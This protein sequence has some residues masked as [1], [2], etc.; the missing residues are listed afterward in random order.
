MTQDSYSLSF[1]SGGQVL[2]HLNKISNDGHYS[3]SFFNNHITVYS[4]N[5]RLAIRSFH[6]LET[7]KFENIIDT[8]ISP[9]NSNL[10]YLLSGSP[11]ENYYIS[12]L[13]W[14][15]NSKNPIL[16]TLK[17]KLDPPST[18]VKILNF[19]SNKETILN[20]LI[21]GKKSYSIVSYDLENLKTLKIFKTIDNV[22][23][24]A[25]SPNNKNIVFSTKKQIPNFKV[26]TFDDD[27]N[28]ELAYFTVNYQ[29][30]K[31][32]ATNL[33]I[34]ND[35]ANP[36]LAFSTSSGTIILLFDL[37]AENPPQRIL[38]WHMGSPK[39]LIFNSDSNYLLSGGSEKVLVFWNILNEKQQFLP[40][41]NGTIENISLNPNVPSLMALSLNVIDNDF[42]YLILGTTDLLSKLDIS[43]PHLFSGM[44]KDNAI[45]KNL[46]KDLHYFEKTGKFSKFKHP[47]K[48]DFKINPKS[49]NLYLQSGRHLQIYDSLHN[50]QIDNLAVAPAVQQY[51]KVGSENKIQDPMVIGSEFV[52]CSK[53]NEMDW[54]V[55]CDAEVR[56]EAEEL[57]DDSIEHWETLRFWKNNKDDPSS[58]DSWTLQT[59]MLRPHGKY[60]ITNIVAAPKSYFGGEAVLTADSRGNV[61]LWRPN[62]QG[63]WSLRKFYSSGSE[64]SLDNTNLE[65]KK[66]KPLVSLANKEGTVCSWSPDSSMIA[67]GKEG[68]VVLLDVNTF[69]PIH[70]ISPAISSARFHTKH[71][72]IEEHSNNQTNGTNNNKSSIVNNKT[73][74]IDINLQDRHIISINFTSNGKLLIIETR[75]HVTV[76]DILKNKTI[77]G[78]MLSY[79]DTGFGGSIVKVTSRN[80]TSINFGDSTDLDNDTT[81]ELL[82]IGNFFSTNKEVSSKLTLWN[83]SDKKSTIKC[84]WSKI[85]NS[86]I[87]GAE[88]SESWQQWILAD[89]NSNIG[90]LSFG[91]SSNK[92]LLLK[93]SESTETSNWIVSSLL[94]NARIVNRAIVSTNEASDKIN[95]DDNTEEFNDRKG[96][97]GSVF[98]GILDHIDGVSVSTLF[99]RVLKVV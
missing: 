3:I 85:Y 66:N 63:I 75:S 90:E 79:K 21:K 49:N 83:I 44:N 54:L 29:N 47:Y 89:I 69:E 87:L 74:Y 57:T 91:K 23:T 77:F 30:P 33:A 39:T 18:I 65:T 4:I 2:S 60:P 1:T 67:I 17:I 5:S 96:L 38:K 86:Q 10:I 46:L 43:T 82:I 53:T 16:S 15:D 88:W 41:L 27:N 76:V 95:L 97:Q 7:I 78:L 8:F 22:N 20:L 12:I 56:G 98:D 55:T 11:G 35:Q 48:L 31:Y 34:S 94:D 71:A 58:K 40:R 84:K 70:T 92:K 51:G 19:N 80:K 6:S 62:S 99:E 61:R 93:E 37:L 13:N 14:Y 25:I 64:N 72:S 45:R 42:Q 26:F 52:Y 32:I 50:L 36:L 68:N 81:D 9:I 73:R 59:K 28:S 24:F